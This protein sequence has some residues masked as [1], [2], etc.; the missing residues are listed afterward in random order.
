M[1]DYYENLIP[2]QDIFDYLQDNYTPEDVFGEKAMNEWGLEWAK[3]EGY[4]QA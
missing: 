3:E 2:I 1:A 4:T